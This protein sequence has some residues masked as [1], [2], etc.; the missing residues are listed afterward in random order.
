M[1]LNPALRTVLLWALGLLLIVYVAGTLR[2]AWP[3]LTGQGTHGAPVAPIVAGFYMRLVLMG[4][5]LYLFERL[6]RG[7]APRR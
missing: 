2:L 3:L 4:I 5:I 7:R 6:R 1:N